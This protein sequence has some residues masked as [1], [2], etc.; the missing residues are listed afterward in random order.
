MFKTKISLMKKVIDTFINTPKRG[1][2]SLKMTP[3]KKDRERERERERERKRI[4]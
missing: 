3:T 2:A 1:R 4:N